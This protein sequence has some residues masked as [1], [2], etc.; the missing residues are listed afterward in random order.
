MVYIPLSTH[1]NELEETILFSMLKN[2]EFDCQKPGLNGILSEILI[3]YYK[4]AGQYMERVKSLFEEYT[5]H[6]KT[7]ILNVIDIMGRI[8]PKETLE[9]LNCL[10]VFLLILSACFHD[11]GM[12]VEE[13]DITQ[14]RAS[15]AFQK[16]QYEFAHYK[17][18]LAKLKNEKEK[19]NSNEPQAKEISKNIKLQEEIHLIA[20]LRDS[21]G[22]RAIKFLENN[23]LRNEDFI[24]DNISIIPILS[25]ICQSHTKSLQDIEVSHDELITTF[26]VNSMYLCLILRLADILDFDR[27]RTP[28]ELLD[29]IS[30]VKS[31]EEWN[32]HLSVLG[33]NISSNKIIFQCEC[34]KPKFQHIINNFLNTIE[35]E[36]LQCKEICNSF[37][38]DFAHYKLNLPLKINRSK[39]IP[40]DKSY[41]YQELFIRLNKEQIINLF[42][43]LHIYN[44]PSLCIRELAQNSI[45]A[46]SLRKAMYLYYDSPQPKLEIN[47]KYILQEDGTEVLICK[48]FGIG[49]DLN[50]INQ[51]LLVSG[52]SYYH[53][54][55]YSNWKTK[56]RQKDIKCEIIAKFG[57]GFFSCFMIGEQI[58]VTTR[59]D[60]GP[61]KGY[62]EPFIIYIDG[63]REIIT[64]SRGH[65]DQEV[66]TQVEIFK[67]KKE[68]YHHPDWDRIR[69]EITINEYFVKTEY[70]INIEVTIPNLE[71]KKTLSPDFIIFP[72]LLELT[73]EKIKTYTFDY[74][75]IHPNLEG[76]IRT[77]FLSDKDGNITIQNEEGKVEIEKSNYRIGAISQHDSAFRTCFNGIVVYGAFGRERSEHQ[78]GGSNIFAYPF[79]S[80]TLNVIGDLQA[81]LD[82][83]RTGYRISRFDPK[84][85]RL[86]DLAFEAYY[87]M[88]GEIIENEK[89]ENPEELWILFTIYSVN[90][91]RL[92]NDRI[93][94][95]HFPFIKDEV[96]EWVKLGDIKEIKLNSNQDSWTYQMKDGAILKLTEKIRS[97]QFERHNLNHLHH[98]ITKFIKIDFNETNQF[99]EISLNLETPPSIEYVPDFGYFFFVPFNNDSIL[100]LEWIKYD[101]NSLWGVFNSAH[102]ISLIIAKTS[103]KSYENLSEKE[104]FCSA[105]M[106]LLDGPGFY[107][108]YRNDENP[109]NYMK[110]I[111]N[112][113]LHLI[114][115]G[116]NL[117]DIIP[118]NVFCKDKGVIQVN[119]ELIR[120]WI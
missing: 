94:E 27:T 109:S 5:L 84:W 118:F 33:V 18:N 64:V 43:G 49:M 58:K 46:L 116:E 100:T 29:R 99:P 55:H 66:G 30:S 90:V 14:V 48:D 59:K 40:K 51:F 117:D 39:I 107:N 6:D 89:I 98:I 86:K 78:R 97:W 34:E 56:F 28:L 113:Y 54:Y 76:G 75:R 16:S 2:S 83:D 7:H 67:Q 25:K 65:K 95:L 11:I 104:K 82:I 110:Y 37:P 13:N 91:L 93:V 23:Y 50:D 21:H 3:K 41:I 87:K 22:D 63:S 20:F 88:W 77:S 111:A 85:R 57:I 4:E 114:N 17:S 62:G 69:L 1:S 53:S 26:Q 36:I 68:I 120:S 106:H 70:P 42:M 101:P 19:M 45:D 105:I 115:I 108:F 32:K 72:T 60:L 61:T 119:D 47:F 80:A 31:M 10:E 73:Y 81:R 44:N 12:Y 9:L 38:H 52:N 35:Q 103:Y 102:P 96:I 92:S 112:Y 15:K 79:S 74:N 8:I 71:V 24:I